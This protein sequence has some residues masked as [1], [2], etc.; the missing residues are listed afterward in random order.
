MLYGTQGGPTVHAGAAGVPVTLLGPFLQGPFGARLSPR[1]A[2]LFQIIHGHP[3]SRP[4]LL[5]ALRHLKPRALHLQWAGLFRL[6]GWAA[7]EVGVPC[8]WELPN[9]VSPALWRLNAR[10]YHAVCAHYGILA[11]ANSAFTA[12]TM[13]PGPCPVTVVPLGADEQ[14]FERARRPLSRASLG[15]PAGAFVVGVV[16]RLHPEKGQAVLLEAIRASAPSRV[17]ALIAGDGQEMARLRALAPEGTVFVGEVQDVERYFP[18]MDLLVN[19]RLTPEPFG[20]SLIEAAF[21]GVPALSHA[22]GGPLEIIRDGSTGLLENDLS[23]L[24]LAAG[25]RR[26]LALKAGGRL[27]AMGARARKDALKR[28]TVKA[29]AA[30]YLAQIPGPR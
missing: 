13:G 14:R 22:A 4:A 3:H 24:G 26:A 6:G 19:W 18:L 5:A 17:T 25:L 16:A 12:A 7:R 8:T 27:K 2:T 21:A 1:Y 10:I 28:F 29:W 30:R 20:L 23:A 11:M 9:L 15:F